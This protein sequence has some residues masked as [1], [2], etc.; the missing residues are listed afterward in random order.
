MQL[1]DLLPGDNPDAAPRLTEKA[2]RE[3]PS[4]VLA[5]KRVVV[6]EDEGITQMQLRRML[7]N[8]GLTVLASAGNGEEGV[9]TVL[10]ERPDLVL[11]DIC[12]PGPFDGLEAARRILAEYHVCLVMLTAFSDDNYRK[13]S[14]EI[15]TCG[16]V[17]KPITTESLIPLLEAAFRNFSQH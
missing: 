13:R 14:A 3:E 17:V 8:A 9:E 6:V 4:L 10:R 7:K 15:R 2:R 11:M 1:Y 5:G 12:M 16:Y